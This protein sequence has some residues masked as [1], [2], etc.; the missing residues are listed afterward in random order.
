M[1]NHLDF[2]SIFNFFPGALAD[3]P[4]LTVLLL[5]GFGFATLAY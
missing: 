4:G 2:G 3:F 5:N 1:G